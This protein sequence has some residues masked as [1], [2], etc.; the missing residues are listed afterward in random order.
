M[1]DSGS[2]SCLA[3]QAGSLG[4]GT[5]SANSVTRAHSPAPLYYLLPCRTLRLT[6]PSC[7]A[8]PSRQQ[9]PA[10][11]AAA[12]SAP[13]AARQHLLMALHPRAGRCSVLQL[14]PL[15]LVHQVMELAAPLQPCH[16]QVEVSGESE[17]EGQE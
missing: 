9:L 14:L 17:G 13:I 4:R 10:L 2:W 16:I 3:G 12:S 8:S 5:V 15:P 11:Q 6:V 7:L 1:G